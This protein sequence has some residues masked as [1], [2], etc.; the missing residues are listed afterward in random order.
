MSSIAS[1]PFP[2]AK[3]PPKKISQ[4]PALRGRTVRLEV[5]DELPGDWD[6]PVYTTLSRTS[7][8]LE[9]GDSSPFVA[10]DDGLRW[11]AWQAT[12]VI[13]RHGQRRDELPTGLQ[14]HRPLLSVFRFVR[15][16]EYFVA[17]PRCD[18]KFVRRTSDVLLYG[19]VLAYSPT[20]SASLV[21]DI[22]L[23]LEPGSGY[24]C[25]VA[26]RRY[27]DEDPQIVAI[28]LEAARAR[29]VSR[30]EFMLGYC[31][32]LPASFIPPSFAQT[33]SGLSVAG[34]SDTRALRSL[35]M[36]A[37]AEP[38]SP[39]QSRVDLGDRAVAYITPRGE[40]AAL[41]PTQFVQHI[42]AV[43]SGDVSTPS[44]EP[45]LPL[46]VDDDVELTPSDLFADPIRLAAPGPAASVAL[47]SS[48]AASHASARP[49]RSTLPIRQTPASNA[50][51]P[52]ASVP[53]RPYATIPAMWHGQ[54][55]D[56][57]TATAPDAVGTDPMTLLANILA[58]QRASNQA[59]TR[60][61][62][63]LTALVHTQRPALPPSAPVEAGRR[64]PPS[65]PVG[66][67][68]GQARCV[69][70]TD[71]QDDDYRRE[72]GSPSP[73][74]S[75]G[76]YLIAH[77]QAPIRHRRRPQSPA[78]RH[79]APPR[80]RSRARSPPRRHRSHT[81]RRRRRWS[82]SRSRSRSRSR[83]ELSRSRR[84]TSRRR[85]SRSRGRSP[86]GLRPIGHA[87][88]RPTEN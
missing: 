43:A 19:Q 82:H 7:K 48:S 70:P 31:Q 49:P 77:G 86:Q 64:T 79:H 78:V 44:P 13:L 15:F 87:A 62:T 11:P 41:S 63:D 75:P 57:P 59:L 85:R 22:D 16:T 74:R 36:T 30:L 20:S 51:L 47:V 3:N 24:V 67:G 46:L 81:P 33:W 66:S 83:H 58:E 54:A 76:G 2:P 40:K 80:S 17:E 38:G 71:P 10:D 21:D 53:A 37:F 14:E 60:Q 9:P 61:M 65:R 56:A 5:P 69:L 55:S 12:L 72:P 68:Q 84:S 52:S 42:T 73:P 18:T 23:L 50:T 32:G 28:P 6:G 27:A 8:M 88:F 25:K 39:T 26:L 34:M 1:K 35:L 45:D 29:H 4:D